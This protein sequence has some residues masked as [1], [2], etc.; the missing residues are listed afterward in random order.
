[1]YGPL[2]QQ[3]LQDIV[4]SAEQYKVDGAI[5]WAFLGCRHTSATIKIIKET[6]NEIDIPMLTIDCDLVDPTINSREDTRAKIEQF[7]E[8]LEDR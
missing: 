5:Y 3:A 4:D 7:I 6:L 2:S 8:L 1:M